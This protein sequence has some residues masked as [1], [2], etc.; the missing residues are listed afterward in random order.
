VDT[1]GCT[2]SNETITIVCAA[3]SAIVLPGKQKNS[4][5][6]WQG[7]GLSVYVLGRIVDYDMVHNLMLN[8]AISINIPA[9]AVRKIDCGC[10]KDKSKTAVSAKQMGLWDE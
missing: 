1:V 2:M 4:R 10:G 5:L 6:R 8:Y 9:I 7:G 3:K